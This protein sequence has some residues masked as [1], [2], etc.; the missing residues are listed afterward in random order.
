MKEPQGTKSNVA[1]TSDFVELSIPARPELLS[2]PRMAVAAIAA[3]RGF[4]VDE[5]EDIRL[6]I[7]ELCLA[8]FEG[9]G[10]GRLH[11]RIAFRGDS[12]EAQCAFAP[13]DD[14]TNVTSPRSE[15]ASQLTEQL[16]NALTDDHGIDLEAGEPRAWFRKRRPSA[17]T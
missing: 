7:E 6:A 8:A 15:L 17:P 4:D 11:I 16:L 2:L 13:D 9:R 10:S 12:L 14:P 1:T 5:V 3:Q